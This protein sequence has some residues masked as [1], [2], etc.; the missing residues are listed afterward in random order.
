MPEQ[1]LQDAEGYLTS[2]QAMGLWTLKEDRTR[3][4][5][6][7][8]LSSEEQHS[9]IYPYQIM[10]QVKAGGHKGDDM[11]EQPSIQEVQ[12]SEAKVLGHKKANFCAVIKSRLDSTC[13]HA[14]NALRKANRSKSVKPLQYFCT[15]LRGSLEH[16]HTSYCRKAKF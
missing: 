12:L 15:G 3:Q 8:T 4:L 9:A 2:L 5:L 6:P 10:E 13:N 1:E 11:L 16:L 7:H 14:R